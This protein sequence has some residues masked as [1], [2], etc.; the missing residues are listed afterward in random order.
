MID[1][2][3]KNSPAK[4]GNIFFLLDS[5]ILHGLAELML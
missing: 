5:I 1:K 2:R 4:A 3:L